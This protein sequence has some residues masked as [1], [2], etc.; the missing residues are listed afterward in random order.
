MNVSAAFVL[1]GLVTSAHAFNPPEG[2]TLEDLKNQRYIARSTIKYINDEPYADFLCYNVRGTIFATY[3]TRS[4]SDSANWLKP[5]WREAY[6]YEV[7]YRPVTST[8]PAWALVAM[9][10]FSFFDVACPTKPV[11]YECH[12]RSRE[13]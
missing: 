3:V 9:E 13:D 1:L 7:K 11:C 8:T 2:V 5:W 4:I 12:S 6:W 10:G